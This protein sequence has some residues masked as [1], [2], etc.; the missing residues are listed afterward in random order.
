MRIPKLYK[1]ILHNIKKTDPSALSSLVQQC[2]KLDEDAA[3]NIVN[4]SQKI[5]RME[6]VGYPLEHAEY[7]EFKVSDLSKKMKLDVRVSVEEDKEESDG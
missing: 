1:L 3:K 4:H 2:F 7:L 6:F 5:F